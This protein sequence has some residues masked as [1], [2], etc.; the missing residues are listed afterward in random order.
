MKK[1]IASMVLAAALV[2][3]TSLTAF[4]AT[5]SDVVGKP[6]Q[7]AVE[8]LS[9]L[10]IIKGYEDGTFKPE[11]SITRA[12]LAKIV[13]IATGNESAAT[14]MA[15]VKPS[16]KDVKAG[17]WYTGYI[18]VAAA[19]GFIQGFNGNYRPSDNVKFEEV[20]AILVRALGY[21]DKHLSGAWPYNVLLK[22]DQIE[23]FDGVEIAAGTLANR[24]VVAEL[25]S[26]TLG[27]T[28]VGYDADGNQ[29]D[30][31]V[32]GKKLA[33]A[34]AL[35]ALINK[36]GTSATK[37]VTDVALNSDKEVS[38]NGASEDTAASFFVTGGQK[39]A[40]LLGHTV[41]VLYNKDGDVLAVTDAQAAKN[42]VTATSDAVTDAGNATTI[43]VNDG[44]KTY[45]TVD[46]LFVYENTDSQAATYDVANGEEVTLLL[47]GDGKVQ[48][49]LVNDWDANLLLD[50][51]VSYKDYSRVTTKNGGTFKVVS[52]SAI[53]LDGK[54]AALADL[55]END[56]INVIVN[57]DSE[58]VN[59]VATRS[60]VSGKL[61]SVGLSGSDVTY[62]VGGKSYVA[63]EDGADLVAGDIGTEYTYY[64]NKDGKI[65][66]YATASAVDNSQYAVVYTAA[67]T[68]VSRI[69]DGEVS[70]N[71][72]YKVVYYSLKDS[73]KVT[74]YTKDADVI[75]L[76]E[77]LVEL[78]FDTDGNIA[79]TADEA[80]AAVNLGS[81]NVVNEV[82]ASKVTVE[83]GVTDTNYILNSGTIYLNVTVDGADTTVA[84]GSAADLTKNDDVAVKADAGV[85]KYVVITSAGDAADLA[86]VQGLYISRAKVSTSATSSTYS[87]NINVNG[88][89]KTVAIDE[90]AFDD[91]AAL[92]KYDVVKLT[93]TVSSNALY[94]TVATV[95]RTA[96]AATLTVN[97][98]DKTIVAGDTTYLVTASTQIIVTQDTFDS[99][100]V[101]SFTDLRVAADTGNYGTG[102]G[103]YKVVV[104]ASGATYGGIAEAGVIIV[105]AY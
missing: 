46:D 67:D 76:D 52:S 98:T 36:L 64:L 43:A 65:V 59:I 78:K 103:Q 15:N 84:V 77:K 86:A 24:G 13:V 29:L 23:L 31:D 49:L 68:T 54:S 104:Q 66:Y 101:G 82:T 58:A 61:E 34:A 99:I 47:N 85:A 6:V 87:A 53:S 70:A 50:E 91:L 79:L 19:K 55:K 10:G 75:A 39:L 3:P 74:A 105:K 69:I 38:L 92:T 30:V 45:D 95:A 88:E 51:V 40:D 25:T 93:D 100:E 41:S 14:L 9:A 48:A 16:F 2:L 26:N 102:A 22:A 80:A 7:S 89:V 97:N 56:V 28:L 81:T 21:Q 33:D 32:K 94:E 5:P 35:V 37:V 72:W 83:T 60:T 27:A 57:D 63:I 96:E 90:D 73:K 71:E 11:N 62:K 20:V 42:I 1:K 18:N 17:A 8:Q 44:A 4:A 12:E